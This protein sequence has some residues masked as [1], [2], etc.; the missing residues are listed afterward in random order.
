MAYV[1][2]LI[3]VA[4]SYIRPAEL[5]P[6]FIPY[7]LAE[8]TGVLALA[9]ALFS[10]L[11]RPRPVLNLPIDWCFL[12]FI[13]VAFIADPLG[14]SAAR[15]GWTA[16]VLLPLAA[17]YVL[18]R[19][20]VETRLQMRVFVV[21]LCTLAVF[22]AVNAATGY[23]AISGDGEIIEAQVPT[24]DYGEE[25]QP[26]RAAT[27]LVG[28][29]MYGDPNDLST[30]LLVV[31]PF[32]LSAVLSAGSGVVPRIA[33]LAALGAIGYAFQLAQ[34]RG[35]FLAL[36][37]LVGAYAYRRMGRVATVI[38]LAVVIVAGLAIGPSR[39]QNID[40]QEASAQGRIE[41]WA[42][43][44]QMVKSH[45]ILG[46][47]FNQFGVL[48]VR[49]AH[50]SFMHVLGEL[51]FVG[52]FLFIGVFYW[53]FVSTSRTRNMAGAASSTLAR[54]LFASG[55]GIVTA[56][57]FLSLQY[58]PILFVPAVLG[59]ARVAIERRP[60]VPEPA[61]HGWDWALI[62]LLVVATIVATWVAVRVLGSWA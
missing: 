55:V 26:D 56:G 9:G 43:G 61:S 2:C 59:A 28:T 20:T 51:G 10:V 30:S 58:V 39:L 32:L 31:V 46:V 22:Q 29:G 12:G 8:V 33:G 34:S 15:L 14:A 19:I 23:S 60:D 38:V 52:G 36:A 54:D 4:V 27:R 57:A 17:F 41:A 45:P 42:A 3:Y 40:S 24:D 47:G 37:A 50:N 18:I 62:G 11:L 7:R 1:L 35:G 48:H 16:Q 25:S 6:A 53:H 44:L 5:N 49:V 13:A 21:V